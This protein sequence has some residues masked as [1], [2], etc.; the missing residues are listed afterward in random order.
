MECWI[1]PAARYWS[2]TA[3]ALDRADSIW[4]GGDRSAVWRQG[5][6]GRD[7]ETR[8]EVGLG[9]EEDVLELA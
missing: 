5:N 6:L 8:V 4:A 9:G 7:K 1:R 3:S 2:R